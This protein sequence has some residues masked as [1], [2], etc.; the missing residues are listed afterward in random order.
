M[1][2]LPRTLHRTFG[3]CRCLLLRKT[4]S[5]HPSRIDRPMVSRDITAGPYLSGGLAGLAPCLAAAPVLSRRARYLDRGRGEAWAQALACPSGRHVCRVDFAPLPDRF[6]WASR[7]TYSG[8]TTPGQCERQ[9][10]GSAGVREKPALPW[11]PNTRSKF[12][13]PHHASRAG[14]FSCDPG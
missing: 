2:S 6:L 5:A 7:S 12:R 3:S 14:E 1:R 9:P 11:N 13:F 4:R 8:F 10:P